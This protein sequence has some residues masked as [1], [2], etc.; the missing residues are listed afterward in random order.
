M[1]VRH[2]RHRPAPVWHHHLRELRCHTGQDIRPR[3]RATRLPGKHLVRR[4]PCAIPDAYHQFTCSTVRRPSCCP[5]PLT[6]RTTHGR[7]HESPHRRSNRAAGS[8]LRCPT[9]STFWSACFFARLGV[10]LR[11]R[12]VRLAAVP[13]RVA[14]GTPRDRTTE[15]S[16]RACRGGRAFHDRTI[17]ELV[18]KL[19]LRREFWFTKP[20]LADDRSV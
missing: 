14:C 1:R 20:W 19:R 18:G 15:H 11:R 4:A 16:D 6:R 12:V 7:Q 13:D 2:C 17:G 8:P 5:P 9:S 3:L 10:L